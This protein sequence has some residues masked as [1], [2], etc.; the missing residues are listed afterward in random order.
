MKKTVLRN[1]I[2]DISFSLEGIQRESQ[3]EDFCLGEA[4]PCFSIRKHEIFKDHALENNMDVS[5]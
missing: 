1:L 4:C 3:V 2:D 5:K